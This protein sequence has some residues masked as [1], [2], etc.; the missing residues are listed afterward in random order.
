MLGAGLL[1]YVLHRQK[2]PMAPLVLG[3][4]L[5][6]MIDENL[7]RT[8]MVHEDLGTL[9]SRPL[10]LLLLG[11]IVIITLV[12]MPLVRRVFPWGRAAGTDSRGSMAP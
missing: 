11:L 6:P 8:F 2:Y 5:G 12:Q 3:T 7:R 9:L 1:F 10:T 4:I